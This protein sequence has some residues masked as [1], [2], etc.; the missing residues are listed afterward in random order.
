VQKF[1]E[2]TT[3]KII[4]ILDDVGVDENDEIIFRMIS[5]IISC[6]YITGY[7]NVSW[8]WCWCWCWLFCRVIY[9]IDLVN[10]SSRIAVLHLQEN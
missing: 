6:L 3:V 9:C 7:N 5:D 10:K 1:N 4:V 2:A 8:C